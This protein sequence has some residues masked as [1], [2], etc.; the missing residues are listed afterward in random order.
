MSEEKQQ[1]L[2]EKN[3]EPQD[4]ILG[5]RPDHLSLC[6]NGIKGKVDVSEL[7]GS[8]VHLHITAEGKDVIVIVLTNG[9]AASFPMGS[10]VDLTFGG[11]VAHI[12]SK[13]TEKNLEW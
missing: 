2:K 1:R 8:S 7:M 10:E 12:F 11:N 6:E 3:V 5:V 13:E 9:A 4:V